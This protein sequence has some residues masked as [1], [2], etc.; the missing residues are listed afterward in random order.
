MRR[1]RACTRS[2]SAGSSASSAV[3]PAA[4]P[5]AQSLLFFCGEPRPDGCGPGPAHAAGRHG[6]RFC[7]S[8]HEGPHGSFIDGDGWQVRVHSQAAARRALGGFF[9]PCSTPRPV[10]VRGAPWAPESSPGSRRQG[11][12]RY[13]STKPW[14]AGCQSGN[15]SAATGS[16]A[17]FRTHFVGAC[18]L[19][20]D[21]S[22]T[23]FF[24]TGFSCGSAAGAESRTAG[25]ASQV[26]VGSARCGRFEVE[27]LEASL[28]QPEGQQT[29]RKQ[30]QRSQSSRR[31][32]PAE[33][34]NRSV[35][36]SPPA[37]RNRRR[38]H[39]RYFARALREYSVQSCSVPPLLRW[40]RRSPCASGGRRSP[41]YRA[42]PHSVPA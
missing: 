27:R 25:G 1:N 22:G 37:P 3:S 40:P 2:A 32:N 5:G 10:R 33:L 15:S 23:G 12:G 34:R 20:T 38:R 7:A 41:L 21:G 36:R 31:L 16:V 29:Q 35:V 42:A 9:G 26:R 4:A 8:R 11:R 6:A 19:D 13:S 28:P 14:A 18:P 39:A 30:A 17:L 24:D